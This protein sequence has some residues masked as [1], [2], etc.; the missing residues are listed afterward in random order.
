MKKSVTLSLLTALLL[1]GSIVSAQTADEI[2]DKHLQSLGGKEQLSKINSLYVEASM[3]VMGTE[4]PVKT[5]T[6]NGKGYK[7]EIE[8]MGSVI[9]NCINEKEGWSINPMMGGN[10]PQMM[11]EEQYKTGKSQIYIGAPFVS[12]KETGYKAELL[13]N[14]SVGDVN[15]L[16]VKMT[17][18]DNHS[19]VYFFD[20]ATGYLVRMIQQSEMQGQMV[21]NIL[22]FSDYRQVDGYTHPFKIHMNVGGMFETTMMTKKVEINKPVDEAIF[23]KP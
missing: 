13:G 18:P 11:T 15:A 20:P 2:I 1:C 14:E 5:T 4:S 21:D 12:Y 10:T 23:A 22:T 16:K 19:E 3:D 6:L 17:S 8:M 9:I 7:T